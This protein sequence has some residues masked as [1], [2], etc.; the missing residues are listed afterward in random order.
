MRLLLCTLCLLACTHLAAAPRI[1]IIIDDLG[2]S[3][4]HDR[5][6]LSLP[7]AITCSVIPQSPHG[8]AMAK[9]AT[10]AGKEVMLHIPMATVSHRRLDP[11]GLHADV[12]RAELN[13]VIRDAIHAIPQAVGLNNHMGSLLTSMPRPMH[14]LMQQLAAK[15][16]FFVDS[17]TTSHSV[18]ARIAQQE[19]VPNLSRDVFLDNTPTLA[20]INRQFNRLLRI[21]RQ[22]GYAIAIGHP[23]ATTANYLRQVLPLLEQAGISLVPV[24][25][26]LANTGRI[27][28]RDGG[29]HDIHRKNT[30]HQSY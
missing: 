29:Q 21:A 2:Y 3:Q 23:Y 7:F 14:W 27:A 15:Q 26:L 22:Q 13:A 4:Q 12:T 28:R 10:A 6:I 20:A 18:A 16:L 24:S 25:E 30:H 8:P 17:L 11:G 19:G 1:A 9:A 5:E